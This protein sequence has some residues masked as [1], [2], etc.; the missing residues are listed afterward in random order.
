[1]LADKRAHGHPNSI[2][3]THRGAIKGKFVNMCLGK[4]QGNGAGSIAI[5]GKPP[6]TFEWVHTSKCGRGLAPDGVSAGAR[7]LPGEPCAGSTTAP[8]PAPAADQSPGS[9]P[10]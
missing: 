5:G 4:A 3:K 6:L 9:P 10:G 2:E 8:T 7:R 1:M